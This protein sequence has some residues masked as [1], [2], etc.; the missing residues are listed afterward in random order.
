MENANDTAS[1]NDTQ[2]S[3]PRGRKPRSAEMPPRGQ[4]WG[5]P[6]SLL[7]DPDPQPGWAFRW[8]R[9][10][11]LGQSD[12]NNLSAARREGWVPVKA[13]DH[14]EIQLMNDPNGR[15]P[16]GVE[17]GGLVLCKIPKE[18]VDQ[19]NAYYLNQ[20]RGQMSSVNNQLMSMNDPR[21]PLF[22]EHRTEVSN[23]RFGKGK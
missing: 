8:I 14:P 7:P 19:R 1:T 23:S 16:D 13:V 5:G 6:A 12:A 4:V 20:A 3:A 21:M 17:V 15:F 22:S 9:L 10:S 2:D 11:S 18:I